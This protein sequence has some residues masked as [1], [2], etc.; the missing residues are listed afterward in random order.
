ME[1]RLKTLY[2]RAFDVGIVLKGLDGLLEVIAGMTLLLATQPALL[3]AV[4]WLTHHELIED[5]A[6]PVANFLLQSV[7]GLPV[8]S[9]HF[10]GAYLLGHG[11]VKLVL[12]TGLLRGARWSYP[13]AVAVLSA[14]IGYQ[15]YRWIHQASF[16]LAAL[17]VLDV[18]IVVLIVKEWRSRRVV[19]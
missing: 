7:Q 4:H 16:F 9:S 15:C 3:G 2:H 19:T 14:F 18:F 11:V 8:G 5:P 17:T 12:V 1:S 10:A 13:A 6:D